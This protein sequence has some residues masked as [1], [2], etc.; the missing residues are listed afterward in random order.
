MSWFT[1][2]GD[3]IAQHLTAAPLWV[4]VPLVLVVL[5]GMAAVIAWVLL[6]LLDEGWAWLRRQFSDQG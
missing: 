3:W 4:Q 1:A 6:W 2:I 5:F